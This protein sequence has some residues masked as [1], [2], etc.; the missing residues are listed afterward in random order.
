MEEP[1]Y[2]M[3]IGRQIVVVCTVNPTY[4]VVVVKFTI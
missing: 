1:F 2:K 4:K 3:T